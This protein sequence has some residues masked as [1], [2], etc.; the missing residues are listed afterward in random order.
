ME[1]LLENSSPEYRVPHSQSTILRFRNCPSTWNW[2]ERDSRQTS[3]LSRKPVELDPGS[4]SIL[5]A[6][7]TV[8][9][10]PPCP[11][12]SEDHHSLH[13][14]LPPSSLPYRPS[15]FLTDHL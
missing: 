12:R 9:L 7:L 5:R 14:P 8:F 10:A 6:P 15:L 11:S 13:V 3:H 2:V 1:I 4:R